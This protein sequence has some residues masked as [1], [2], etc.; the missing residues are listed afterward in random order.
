LP[1]FIATY[2]NVSARRLPGRL[3]VGMPVNDTPS[4]ALMIRLSAR[5][6]NRLSLCLLDLIDDFGS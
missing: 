1:Q 5:R 2:G 6:R 4:F 3:L